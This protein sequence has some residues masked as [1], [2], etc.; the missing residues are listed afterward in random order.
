MD[1]NKTNPYEDK[2]ARK[3][4]IHELAD[5]VVDIMQDKVVVV[6]TAILAS[7]MLMH[8]KGTSEEEL[9]KKVEWVASELFARGIKVGTINESSPTVAFKSAVQHLESLISKKKDIFH[10]TV[11]VKNDYKNILMLSYYRNSLLFAFFNEALIV[12][13]L[14]GFGYDMAYK[15][16][17][18]IDRLLEETFYLRDLVDKEITKKK[19]LT[20]EGFYKLLDFMV[21]KSILSIEGNKVKV[22]L[23][24][25]QFNVT[26]T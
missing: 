19:L 12:C 2:V 18:S 23:I 15:E 4:L 7:V 13:S 22:I 3:K 1:K 14:V 16:G 6:P 20:K 21:N 10:P 8:R 24:L 11:V 5:D 25:K 26:N 17:V 9:I